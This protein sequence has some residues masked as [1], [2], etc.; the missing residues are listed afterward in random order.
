MTDTDRLPKIA[1]ALRRAARRFGTPLVVTDDAEL[2]SARDELA[3]AFPD[4]TIR[5]FSVKANDVPGIVARLGALG[6]GANVVSRGE[7]AV[8]RRAGIPN[9]RI[10]LEGIGKTDADLRAVVR[11]TAGHEPLLWTAIES[12]A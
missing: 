2:A 6:M 1:G 7:W 12:A 11:A 4:P 9:D 10:S 3:L 5:Q 8:A